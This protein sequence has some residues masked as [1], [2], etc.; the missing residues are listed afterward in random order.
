MIQILR[1]DLYE[2][3]IDYAALFTKEQV[4]AAAVC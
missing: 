2:E 1:P 3:D 4:A